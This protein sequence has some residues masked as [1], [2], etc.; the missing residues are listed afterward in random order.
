MKS[1]FASLAVAATIGLGSVSAFAQD[2]YRDGGGQRAWQHQRAEQARDRWGHGDRWEH[3]QRYSAP[4]YYGPYYDDRRDDGDVVGAIVLGALAGALLGQATNAQH[5]GT[6]PA[7]Y[8][9]PG[10]AY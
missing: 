4:A 8:Y 10:Y 9:N 1:K 2:H 6:P 5:Y 7:A 3:D